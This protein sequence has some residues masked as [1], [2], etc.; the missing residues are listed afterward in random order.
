MSKFEIVT[1]SLTIKT[2]EVKIELRNVFQTIVLTTFFSFQLQAQNFLSFVHSIPQ[3]LNKWVAFNQLKDSTYPFGFIYFDTQAGL[4]LEYGGTFT[5]ANNGEYIPQKIE[6][7]MGFK[8]RLSPTNVKVAFVSEDKLKEL[9]V[10][11]IPDW[12]EIYNR[13]SSTINRM[14]KLG[15]MFNE[16]NECELAI[17]YLQKVHNIDP[18]FKNLAVELAFSYNCLNEFE[19]AE[20]ILEEDLKKN[21]KDDYVIKEYLFS[22]VQNNKIEK[23]LKMFN[24]YLSI[25]EKSKYYAEIDYNILQYYFKVKDKVNFAKWY[26]ALFKINNVS[27]GIKQYADRMKAELNK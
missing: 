13:D 16:W 5:I 15:F 21:P 27:V 19:K 24:S 23:T 3:G 9:K 8:K 20:T 26:D 18:D 4:T 10:S 22:L 2:S 7:T 6:N 12:L 17:P 11:A 25:I 1:S 14:F